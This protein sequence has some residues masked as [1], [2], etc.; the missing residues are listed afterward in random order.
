MSFSSCWVMGIYMLLIGL[1]KRLGKKWEKGKR[2]KSKTT[3]CLVEKRKI[4]ETKLLLFS[5]IK[6]EEKEV[7]KKWKKE[8]KICL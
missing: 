4:K 8:E 7:I 6:S 1:V 3:D 2:L 5:H